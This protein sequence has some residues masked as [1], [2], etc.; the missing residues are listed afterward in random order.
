MEWLHPVGDKIIE[1]ADIMENYVVL[2]VATGTG[3]PG[4]SAAKKVSRGK[5]VGVDLSEGMLNVANEKARRLVISNYE[6]HVH[7]SSALPFDDNYF[8][9]VTSRFGVMFLPNILLGLKEMVRVLKPTRRLVVSVWGPQDERAKYV[10]QILFDRLKLPGPGPDA[11]GPYRCSRRGTIT[12]LLTESG[13][14]GV[15]EIELKGQ[16]TWA[17]PDHYWNFV[18]DINGTIAATLRSVSNDTR[19]RAKHE[20]GEALRSVQEENGRVSFEWTAWIDYG[21][22]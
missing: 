12:S 14:H 22:K 3:E 16:R 5:V 10:N 2:D 6:T 15:A 13:L 9:A 20:V 18:T 7:D 19:G 11:P 21:T 4:L 1:V 8:D 17:S